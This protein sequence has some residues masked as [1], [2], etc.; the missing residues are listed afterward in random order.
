[1]AGSVAQP[2][3]ADDGPHLLLYDGVCGLCDALVQAVLRADRRG[4]FHFASLQS[5]AGRAAVA[6]FGVDAGNLTT[7][8]VVVNYRTATPMPLDRGR[9]ALFVMA[10]L[11][12]PWKVAAVLRVL[13]RPVVDRLYDL[14]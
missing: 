12:W 4:V 3:M 1:M 6:P 8:Y 2:V 7:M 9:A 5:R 10:S 11:G 13:P 14:V